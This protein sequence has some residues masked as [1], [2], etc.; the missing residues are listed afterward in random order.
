MKLLQHA[1]R[2]LTIVLVFL[3]IQGLLAVESLAQKPSWLDQYSE[4]Q[5]YGDIY[6]VKKIDVPCLNYQSFLVDKNGNK[7]TTAY[8]DIGE[9]SDG[10]AEFVPMEANAS[11]QG[12]HGFI[13]KKGKV[14][15]PAD[16]L[17]TDKFYKGKTW[18]IYPAGKQ[19]GLSYIDTTG[20]TL[21]RIPIEYFKNDFLM[22]AATFDFVC[23]RD[24][25]EDIIWW[26]KGELY[27]LNW[28]FSPFIEKEIKESSGIYH[29]LYKGKYGIVDKNLVLKIPVALDD[30]DPEYKFSGQGMERVKYGDKYGYINVFTGEMVTPFEFTKTRK[31]TNG[32]FWVQ[33][34]KKWGCIDKTGKVRIPFLYDE[35]NG[36][37]AENRT[38]V[39]IN[40]KFGHI[41]KSGK[42]RTPLKYDCASY[43]QNGRSLV[44]IKDKYGYIDVN[45]K[46]VTP[47]HYDYALPFDEITTTA[48]RNG[49]RYELTLDGK[50]RFV[51]FSA[52]W[53]GLFILLGVIL[54]VYINSYFFKRTQKTGNRKL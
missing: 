15:V 2:Y 37:T 38:A 52:G 51:G 33:K 3:Q 26:K 53:N 30:I 32:L 10:L 23:N 8:R 48:N 11:K 16:Y 39:S 25:K 4:H 24:T 54:I 40:G 1:G 19:Y 21:Y 17:G 50:E 34:K 12:L 46:L 45:D 41:Y 49:L 9:F 28:N 43:F 6:V 14:I 44:R 13:N 29:F 31:P 35:A 20:K 7:L 47:I 18:V 5:Q 22:T 27:L 42:I 36:F